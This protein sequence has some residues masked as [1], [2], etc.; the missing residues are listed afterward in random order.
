MRRWCAAVRLGAYV[1]LAG[2]VVALTCGRRPTGRGAEVQIAPAHASSSPW[3]PVADA[4]CLCEPFEGRVVA[5]RPSLTVQ[6]ADLGRA[7]DGVVDIDQHEAVPL[8]TCSLRPSA[9]RRMTLYASWEPS[10]MTSQPPTRS[11]AVGPPLTAKLA[12]GRRRLGLAQPRRRLG[13]PPRCRWPL[14][15][16]ILA[17]KRHLLLAQRLPGRA[18]KVASSAGKGHALEPPPQSR[19]G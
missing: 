18:R 19:S 2:R 1:P 9:K 3:R 12:P 6:D 7:D 4:P 10:P 14:E 11:L 13:P 15:T 5:Q 8:Q 16:S 17:L